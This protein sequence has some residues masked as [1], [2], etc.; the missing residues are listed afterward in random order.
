MLKKCNPHEFITIHEQITKDGYPTNQYMLDTHILE[1]TNMKNHLSW[2]EKTSVKKLFKTNITWACSKVV[3][4]NERMWV[5]WTLDIGHTTRQNVGK[6]VSKH[7]KIKFWKGLQII[8][9]WTFHI[10]ENCMQQK[11]TYHFQLLLE[12]EGVKVDKN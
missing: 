7:F 10:K 12:R 4:R 2:F 11:V 8:S 1:I 9:W 3:N 6:N 5:R